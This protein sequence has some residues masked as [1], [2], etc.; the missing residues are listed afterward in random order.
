MEG[1]QTR[2]NECSNSDIMAFLT[3]FF[4]LSRGHYQPIYQ[5]PE[6]VYLL[7]NLIYATIRLKNKRPPPIIDETRDYKRLDVRSFRDDIESA[8][9]HI[10]SIFDT[11]DDNLW[12]WKYLFND[13]CDKH[14]PWKNVKIRSISYMTSG[15]RLKMNRRYKL[16]KEAVSTKCSRKWSAYK[17]ARNSVTSELRKG[18]T[19]YFSKMFG[20]VQSTSAYWYLIKRAADPKARKT[21][22]PVKRADG[23]LALADQ[24]KARIMNSYLTTVG[25][26]LANSFPPISGKRQGA[27]SNPKDNRTVPLLNIPVNPKTAHTPPPQAIPGHLTHVKLRTIENLTQNEG[28][29]VGHLTFVLKRLSAVG[30]KRISQFFDSS[31]APRSR[32]FLR[33][34]CCCC[35]YIIIYSYIVEYAFV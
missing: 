1:N 16:F 12:A 32:V 9:F 30:N 18:K 26:N 6:G 14:A 24:G 28:R 19:A 5:P 17:K 29:P 31:D 33:G 3:C 20:E 4:S 35:R 22:G 15:I 27:N 10:A 25:L 7:N 13:L 34:F 11:P 2:F 23:T 8:L 21:I